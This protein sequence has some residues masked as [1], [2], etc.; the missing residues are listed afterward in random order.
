MMNK[1]DW[2]KEAKRFERKADK[3]REND[4]IKATIDLSELAGHCWL[5][6]GEAEQYEMKVARIKREKQRVSE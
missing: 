1:E 3:A 6:A 5:K 4:E 2:I